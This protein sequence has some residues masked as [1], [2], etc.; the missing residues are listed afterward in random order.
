MKWTGQVKSC[1]SFEVVWT[2]L[3]ESSEKRRA[4]EVHFEVINCNAKILAGCYQC[5]KHVN[6]LMPTAEVDS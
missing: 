6:V 4:D 3:T 5:C 1:E 2:T